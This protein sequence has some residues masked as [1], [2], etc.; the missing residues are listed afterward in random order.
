[1]RKEERGVNDLNWFLWACKLQCIHLQA[2]FLVS[3]YFTRENTKN[4]PHSYFVSATASS[5]QRQLD[6]ETMG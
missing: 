2:L 1:M 5:H 4:F 3:C 6:K